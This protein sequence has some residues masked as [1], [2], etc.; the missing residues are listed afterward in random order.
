MPDKE[1]TFRDYVDAEFDRLDGD[2]KALKELVTSQ[3]N[4]QEKSVDT[5]LQSA[6]RA[7]DKTEESTRDSFTKV[8]EFRGALDDLSTT[9][10]TRKELEDTKKS[11][12][13]AIDELRTR[14]ADL[15]SRLDKNLA[16]EH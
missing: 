9:M 8:N 7:T 4:A 16:Y 13:G 10:S 15:A 2:I 3:L 12:N 5:A 6:Q 1:V 11:I 14:L